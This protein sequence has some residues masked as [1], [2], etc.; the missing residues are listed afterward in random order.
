[1]TAHRR[2][3]KDRAHPSPLARLLDSY[4]K[5]PLLQ[6]L[7]VSSKPAPH[8][9]L[10]K[11]G[12]RVAARFLRSLG[13]RMLARNLDTPG[14]EADLV[15]LDEQHNSLVLVE[16]KTRI[17]S[18]TSTAP[19]T[20]AAINADKRARLLKTAKA[21]KKKRPYANKPIRIDVITIEYEQRDDP[22][23]AIKHYIN[24]VRAPSSTPGNR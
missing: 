8:L 21:L 18:A 19:P 13:Y 11:Q 10:G 3:F 6:R 4:I 1:M 14:G 5:H 9:A 7:G 23:P 2:T 16:V 15:C 22:S 20:T 17:R 12:E 24:A